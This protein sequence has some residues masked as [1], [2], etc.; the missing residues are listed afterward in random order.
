MMDN[1][2]LSVADALALSREGEVTMMDSLVVMEV[3]FSFSFSFQHGE[4]IGATVASVE[5]V[6][7]EQV[8]YR[9]VL[10]ISQ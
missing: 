3:G 2:G 4:E 1:G 5:Q 10:T 9:E 7:Q 8:N 6:Q